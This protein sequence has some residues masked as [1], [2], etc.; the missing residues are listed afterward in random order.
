MLTAE[1][2]FVYIREFL[3]GGFSRRISHGRSSS[4]RGR[5]TTRVYAARRVSSVFGRRS[6]DRVC[7]DRRVFDRVRVA[8]ARDAR[9]KNA[10]GVSFLFQQDERYVFSHAT[11]GAV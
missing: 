10:S 6:H 11:R 3:S 8:A 9:S 4:A 1:R 7:V 5:A 2:A